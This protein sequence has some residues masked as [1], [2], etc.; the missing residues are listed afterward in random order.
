MNKKDN[1]FLIT[2]NNTFEIKNF[3][4][5]WINSAKNK[6]GDYNVEVFDF[7][8]DDFS[9]INSVISTPPF[10]GEEKRIFFLEN[11]PIKPKSSLKENADKLLKSILNLND[12][13]LIMYTDNADKR[14]KIY[15]QVLEISKDTKIFSNW[16]TDYSGNLSSIGTAQGIDWIS[17]K[18]LEGGVKIEK[19]IAEFLLNHCG[20]NLFNLDSEIKK[21]SIFSLT[22]KIE[23]DKNIIKEYCIS[24]NNIMNFELA[25]AISSKNYR[26]FMQIL[27]K[28]IKSG[29][30]FQTILFRDILPTIRQ[31]IIVKSSIENSIDQKNSGLHPF[32]FKKTISLVKNINFEKLK[33]T[34][35][36]LLNIDFDLKTGKMKNKIQYFQIYISKIFIDLFR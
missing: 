24:E 22:T 28:E 6:Y 15:K 26:N 5:I 19:N 14:T 8:N 30:V 17:K 2:G 35:E 18:F 7:E 4:R 23:I 9:L 32:V 33:N 12:S 21:L 1:I 13:V 16:E 20:N 25:N 27:D 3:V 11:Y 31:M 36:N 29:E 34:Y 10:F